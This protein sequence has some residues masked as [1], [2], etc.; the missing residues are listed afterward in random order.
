VDECEEM[1][2]LKFEALQALNALKLKSE[3]CIALQ[4]Q[5]QD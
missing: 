4:K 2:L 1:R 3:E 5:M